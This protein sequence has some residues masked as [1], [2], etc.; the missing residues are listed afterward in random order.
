MRRQAVRRHQHHQVQDRQPRNHV[1]LPEARSK[2]NS[3]LV[4]Q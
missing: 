4:K 2:T 1:H 3:S